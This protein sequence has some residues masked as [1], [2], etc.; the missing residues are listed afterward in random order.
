MAERFELNSNGLDGDLGETENG[1]EDDPSNCAKTLGHEELAEYAE[2]RLRRAEHRL[3]QP[4][5]QCQAAR[6]RHIRVTWQD[7]SR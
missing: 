1:T 7:C 3:Q 4:P 2:Q 5:D 6:L